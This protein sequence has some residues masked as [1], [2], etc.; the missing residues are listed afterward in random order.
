MKITN[1]ELFKEILDQYYPTRHKCKC[2]G[3]DIIYDDT[4]LSLYRGKCN[5]AGKSFKNIKMVNDIDC[6]PNIH[7]LKLE[8]IQ[9][10]LCLPS[11]LSL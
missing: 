7:E 1:K 11:P 6:H 8:Y 9:E 2:C 4:S 3:N 5:I 10:I